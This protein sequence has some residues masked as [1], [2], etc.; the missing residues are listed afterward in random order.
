M[1]PG[2]QAPDCGNKLDFATDADRLSRELLQWLPGETLFSLLR[3]LHQLWGHQLADQTADVLSGRRRHGC[4]HDFP[5]GPLAFEKKT[6]GLRGDA[7]S[8]ALARTLLRYYRPF[9]LPANVDGSIAMMAS[10]SVAH[11]KFRLGL[12]TSRF[13]AHYPLKA[14]PAC[15]PEDCATYGWASGCLP[16]TRSRGR[17]QSGTAR[18]GR[19]HECS[20]EETP[21]LVW[22]CR[23]AWLARAHLA[24]VSQ[25]AG[26]GCAQAPRTQARSHRCAGSASSLGCQR[27]E[28]ENGAK[29]KGKSKAWRPS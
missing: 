3:R 5:S 16:T 15:I 10:A 26:I 20:A 9:L 19:S 21:S 4:Q 18:T 29:G 2:D 14:C 17:G 25:V 11:P 28:T 27:S 7:Q 13:R 24:H 23:L 12:L 22:R 8:I 1:R 6:E